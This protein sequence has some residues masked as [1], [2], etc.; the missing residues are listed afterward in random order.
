MRSVVRRWRSGLVVL[1]MGSVLLFA[2]CAETMM[3]SEKEMMK[4]K[5]MMKKEGEMMK[6]EKGTME[7]KQ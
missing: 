2:G 4:E 5:G 1:V 3:G 7:K 6:E